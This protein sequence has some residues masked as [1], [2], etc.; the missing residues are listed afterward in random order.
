MVIFPQS[1]IPRFNEKQ[2]EEFSARS[3]KEPAP[4]SGLD[5]ENANEGGSLYTL[6]DYDPAGG[7]LGRV[8]LMLNRKV[9]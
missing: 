6:L 2:S 7:E 5:R 9:L 8:G 4:Q 1:A 3:K